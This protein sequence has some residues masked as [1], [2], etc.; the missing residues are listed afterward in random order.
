MASDA[1]SPRA[2]RGRPSPLR[3]ADEKGSAWGG[4]LNQELSGPWARRRPEQVAAAAGPTPVGGEA[5]FGARP[6][7]E[8]LVR[9]RGD[10]VGWN[11]LISLYLPPA[12]LGAALR[13]TARIAVPSSG[14]PCAVTLPGGEVLHLPFTPV[15]VPPEVRWCWG[16]RQHGLTLR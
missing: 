3:P 11:C 7:A 2:S 16:G 8:L 13:A 15:P 4:G 5:L 1:A 6:A 12:N 9:R 10:G 14:P